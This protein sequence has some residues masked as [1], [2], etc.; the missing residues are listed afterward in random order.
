MLSTKFTLMKI[1]SMLTYVI[2]ALLIVL[3]AGT[4]LVL[5][6]DRLHAIPLPSLVKHV[7]WGR[8]AVIYE[9]NIRQYSREGT[10]KAFEK[11][12][13]RLKELGVEILW[14]MPV[15]PI[16][17]KN[18][19]GKLG[20]YYS[21]KDYKAINPEFG[22]MNDFKHLV[23]SVHQLG[24][25]I[26]IDWVPNHTAWDNKLFETHPEYYLKDSTGKYAS[27]FDWTDVVRLDYGNP[28]TRKYMIETMQW[29][30]TETDIDGFRCDVAHMVPT[31]FWDEL[32]PQLEKIK[33]IFMLAEADIPMQHQK[34][35]DMS[36][37]WKFHHIMNDIAQ[38]K[39]NANAIMRHFNH[40]DSV[41]PGNSYLMEFTSNH[42]E[43]SWNGTEYQRMGEGAKTF[44]VLASTINGMLLIYN[45]QESAFNRSLQF[46]VKDSIDWG[47]YQLA[48]FYKTL[49]SLKKKNK[50]LWNG[51]EGGPIKRI[52]SN[53]DSAVFAFSREKGDQGIVVICNLSSKLLSVKLNT[54]KLDGNYNEI[55]S[56]EKRQFKPITQLNLKP[57]QYLVFE[58]LE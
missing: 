42:D 44:A 32:R 45:G 10:L 2:I 14:I 33:P 24:L 35:F 9:V 50:A 30:L 18:R 31:D 8:N 38:G 56:N 27:P 54:N 39:K 11:D 52:T 5:A 51:D 12:L 46:F 41:Y 47:Q 36:Y 58:K 6:Q 43:N 34:A 55:F 37:D 53:R 15:N 48:P 17:E 29:W 57:W 25:K 13:P 21:V 1:H 19:K 28:L 22:T 3:G 4:W 20:S 26:I 7:E 40:V 49:I 23:Q 16:G